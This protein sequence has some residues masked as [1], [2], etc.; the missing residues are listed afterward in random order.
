[1]NKE[2]KQSKVVVIAQNVEKF[3]RSKLSELMIVLVFLTMLVVQLI[4]FGTNIT[5]PNAGDPTYK[6]WEVWT[7]ITVTSIGAGFSLYGTIFSI[8]GKNKF[9]K[10]QVISSTLFIISDIILHLLY[11]MI[12]NILFVYL[13]YLRKVEWSKEQKEG[14]EEVFKPV[15]M[16]AKETV[17]YFSGALILFAGLGTLMFFTSNWAYDVS[18]VW[19]QDPYP[20][21][22]AYML[23]FS[24]LG[25]MLLIKKNIQ[26]WY[27][28]ASSDI[29]SVILW[30][31]VGAYS[32]MVMSFM[33]LTL[34]I[35]TIIIWTH[36]FKQQ[37]L[38]EK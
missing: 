37:Q 22:D 26:G 8:R 3:W 25:A 31:L 21:L 29:L 17:K 36:L 20:Y 12:R 15:M 28:F 38:K 34:D 30:C 6:D 11:D 35:S 5:N 27:A 1:M 7:V 2:L 4:L 16:K 9:F 24:M 14:K 10:Y 18:F 32:S 23:V 13:F 19:L 33:F